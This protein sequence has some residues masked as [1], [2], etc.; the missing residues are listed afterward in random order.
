[1]SNI[2]YRIRR[3]F[4]D[5]LVD[6]IFSEP[7]LLGI[8]ESFVYKGKYEHIGAYVPDLV[9]I[10]KTERT[11]QRGLYKLLAV[12]VKSECFGFSHKDAEIKVYRILDSFIRNKNKIIKKYSRKIGKNEKELKS[13]FFDFLLAFPSPETANGISFVKPVTWERRG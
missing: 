7:E 10:C 4:H 11:E 13:L 8:G 1:M 3:K 9:F 12:E 5:K 2:N 6:K